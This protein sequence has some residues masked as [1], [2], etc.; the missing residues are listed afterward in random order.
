MNIVF[1][2]EYGVEGLVSTRS[3][4]YSYGILLMETF[5]RRKPSDDM[6][7]GE[8]SLRR[9][10]KDSMPSQIAQTIDPNLLREEDFD[11][12]LQCALSVMELALKCSEDLP[13]MRMSMK[14]VVKE[15]N[16]I[17]LQLIASCEKSREEMRIQ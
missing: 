4:A 9:W 1:P 11:A 17:Q 7:T 15:L 16:K 2:T 10:I 8:L 3:D 5:S 13:E 12:K 14:D 6:F